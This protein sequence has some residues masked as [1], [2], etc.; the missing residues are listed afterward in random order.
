MRL[1]KTLVVVIVVVIVELLLLVGFMQSMASTEKCNNDWDSP[2][3]GEAAPPLLLV[4]LIAVPI[5]AVWI[6]GRGAR[7]R[8]G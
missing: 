2:L 6:S 4:A 5:L 3:C 8:D 7:S 1:A